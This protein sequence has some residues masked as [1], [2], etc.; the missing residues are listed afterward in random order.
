[1]NYTAGLCYLVPKCG[2]GDVFSM[3]TSCHDMQRGASSE[4]SQ[5]MNLGWQ[6]LKEMQHVADS[7]GHSLNHIQGLRYSVFKQSLSS[8][9]AEL[10]S[11]IGVLSG[12]EGMH[13]RLQLLLSLIWCC[14]LWKRLAPACRTPCQSVL[15][16][17]VDT[18]SVA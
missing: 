13:L 9:F 11:I 1:M 3:Q 4:H 7:P 6:V 5:Q 18:E 12:V 8:S 2:E 17:L 10:R 14:S 16:S 15:V